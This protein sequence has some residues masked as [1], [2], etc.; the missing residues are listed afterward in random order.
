M[1]ASCLLLLVAYADKLALKWAICRLWTWTCRGCGLV[2][3]QWLVGGAR[4]VELW[5]LSAIKLPC[6]PKHSWQLLSVA[7][8]QWSSIKYALWHEKAIKS[9]VFSCLRENVCKKKL[10]KLSPWAKMKIYLKS[11]KQKQNFSFHSCLEANESNL[12]VLITF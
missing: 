2:R 1:S 9:R 10:M 12:R 5:L 11:G 6:I 4:S 7:T 3:G 8:C